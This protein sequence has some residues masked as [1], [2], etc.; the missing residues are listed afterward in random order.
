MINRF[1]VGLAL[2]ACAASS[3][4][5]RVAAE[6]YHHLSRTTS[7]NNYSSYSPSVYNNY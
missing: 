1:L 4:E 5:I 3:T 2:I 7:N 6:N